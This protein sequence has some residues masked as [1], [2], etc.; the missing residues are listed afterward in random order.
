MPI[1]DNVAII[2]TG[3]TKFSEHFDLEGHLVLP[4]FYALANP[5]GCFADTLPIAGDKLET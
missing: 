2:G 5:S 1:S 3:V 4:D